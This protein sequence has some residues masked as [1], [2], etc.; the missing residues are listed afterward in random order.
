MK[1]S[2][3]AVNAALDQFLSL[4]NAEEQKKKDGKE[5]SLRLQLL[6]EQLKQAQ[7]YEER[8][9]AKRE[10]DRA[11]KQ[12]EREHA[13][14]MQQRGFDHSDERED[15][16]LGIE[17]ER[18]EESRERALKSDIGKIVRAAKNGDKYI[19]ATAGSLGVENFLGRYTPGTE[20]KMDKES[21]NY[22]RVTIAQEL[23]QITDASN[24]KAMT[25][26]LENKMQ[27]KGANSS[28]KAFKKFFKGHIKDVL[29]K[30]ADKYGVDKEDVYRLYR[31]A[32][33]ESVAS[34][35]KKDLTVDDRESTSDDLEESVLAE[36]PAIDSPSEANEEY[37]LL[38]Q[39]YLKTQ[40]EYG[41]YFRKVVTDDGVARNFPNWVF[42]SPKTIKS[43]FEDSPELKEKLLQELED[44]KKVLALEEEN[45]LFDEELPKYKEKGSQGAADFVG[46]LF[47]APVKL[48]GNVAKWADKTHPGNWFRKGKSEERKKLDR[49]SE[50]LAHRAKD[51]GINIDSGSFKAGEMFADAAIPLPLA[52]KMKGAGKL[53]KVANI[54]GAGAAYGALDNPDKPVKGA[55]GGVAS[56]LGLAGVGKLAK[57]F[58]Y[59]FL[60]GV[61]G[62]KK[63]AKL[64]AES[65][66]Y[67][68]LRESV[69]RKR[70]YKYIDESEKIKVL[71]K[72]E[73]MNKEKVKKRFFNVIDRPNKKIPETIDVTRGGSDSTKFLPEKMKT[74]KDDK[75]F[76]DWFG[77]TTSTSYN[78]KEKTDRLLKYFPGDRDVILPL[79]DNNPHMIEQVKKA[80]TTHPEVFI[81][82]ATRMERDLKNVS[83]I[84]GETYIKK[85]RKVAEEVLILTKKKKEE[86]E[87]LY[88]KA[89]LESPKDVV[90]PYEDAKELFVGLYPG[91]PALMEKKPGRKNINNSEIEANFLKLVKEEKYFKSNPEDYRK[92]YENMKMPGFMDLHFYRSKL[93][94]EIKNYKQSNREG[95]NSDII[96]GLTNDLETIEKFMKKMEN[97][98]AYRKASRYYKKEV[99]PFLT[100]TLQKFTDDVEL[101]KDAGISFFQ[102]E[103]F[104]A[105]KVFD[106]L[107]VEA[108]NSVI[109]EV[110][111][112]KSL[113]ITLRS[114]KNLKG[115]RGTDPEKRLGHLVD[116][117]KMMVFEEMAD[118]NRILTDLQPDIKSPPTGK[119]TSELLREIIAG[120]A[121]PISRVL[122]LGRYLKNQ[123][124]IEKLSD[125]R[126][127]SEYNEILRKHDQVSENY[128]KE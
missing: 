60:G 100:H 6:E 69:E 52:G 59:A 79:V 38:K 31:E 78:S 29:D 90:I 11:L 97:I 17:R 47:G 84:L 12:E 70:L 33:G 13:E 119:A 26:Y 127:I 7:T 40:G 118:L 67:K 113:N 66:P 75:R 105:R 92:V 4:W 3:R 58:G 42:R 72:T 48:A 116:D 9:K 51:A 22:L 14:K 99:A 8:E 111:D 57:G 83:N 115:G 43:Y 87:K 45:V 19:K 28:L 91:K 108:Q 23:A 128:K 36:T 62:V 81:K 110:L 2:G 54:A 56:S 1:I 21:A 20:A 80:A 123:N 107:S 24:Q 120:Q 61:S 37:D 98:K 30:T 94:K 32:R 102:K 121:S 53:K 46:G 50:N 77:D 88:R 5:H 49:L 15:I 39:N 124:T 35:K 64:I 117:E 10:Y 114:F 82:A 122:R 103:G 86:A 101:G 125:K 109:A 25:E 126:N 16:K 89:F 112:P 96:N 95:K 74:D 18:A 93:L 63:G 41:K 85:P 71:P 76:S 68:H 65:N 34:E 55:A 73:Y 44:E 27:V 104:A 106:Q